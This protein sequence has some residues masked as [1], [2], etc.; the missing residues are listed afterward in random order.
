MIR[1]TSTSA[2]RADRKRMQLARALLALAAAAPSPAA[3]DRAP[4]EP[5]TTA[6]A[7]P[8]HLVH[9]ADHV[10]GTVINLTLWTDRDHDAAR[11]ATAVFAEF[12]RIEALMTSWT[13]DSAVARITQAA[14]KGPVRVDR[15]TFQV[16]QR[17]QEIARLTGGAFDVTLGAFHN[18]WRF[19]S[20]QTDT[21]PSD[22]AIADQVK[23]VDYRRVRLW[24]GKRAVTLSR[25]GMAITL[26]GIAKGYAVDRAAAILV[27]AGFVDFI[28]Q[29]GG[30]LLVSG[31]RGDRKWRVGIRDPRGARTTPFAVADI[32]DRT[33]STSGDYERT[34]IKDGVRYHHILDPKTG[35][36][37]R[38]CR[39]VTVMA[40]DAM[41]ADGL[42]TALFVM[43]PDAGMALVE[44]LP[45]V[46]AVFVDADNQLHISTGLRGKLMVL[47]PP[48]DGI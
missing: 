31:Q 25:P 47:R 41:T 21:I 20:H 48:T 1:S 7:N 42:S 12:R 30:D 11:A 2:T 36:P 37:A 19:G 32:Q 13:D 6:S 28:I 34:F 35:R 29:A 24:P 16:V 26:G 38:T 43:G 18:L 3:A 39:S 23:L 27:E 15:E 44:T 14:G 10:M 17:A 5:A 45:E 9:R 46:E 8:D 22:R 33:F 40:K 4:A